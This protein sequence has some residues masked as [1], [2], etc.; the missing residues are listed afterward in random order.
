MKLYGLE[1]PFNQSINLSISQLIDGPSRTNL[2]TTDKVHVSLNPFPN[3]PWFLCVCSTSLLKTLLE[4]EKL[5]ITS[6]FSFSH[7]VFYLFGNFS[8]ILS[9]IKSSSANSLVWKNLK[10][11]VWER[12]NTLPNN[13]L[14]DWFKVTDIKIRMTEKLKFLLR[15]VENIVRK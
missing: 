12:V 15:R 4:K 8:A 2:Q 13:K 6:N 5:L 1:T 9:N 10:F 3:K 14:V 11:V 7:R